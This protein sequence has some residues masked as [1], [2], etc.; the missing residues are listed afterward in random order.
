MDS[1]P[2]KRGR[3]RRFDL[4]AAAIQ[5][6]RKE[7]LKIWE[8]AQRC[9]CSN[10]TVCGRLK[11]AEEKTPAVT[12]PVAPVTETASA[13]LGPEPTAPETQAASTMPNAVVEP[14]PPPSGSTEPGSPDIESGRPEVEGK[15]GETPPP[16]AGENT[17][18]VDP[19]STPEDVPQSQSIILPGLEPEAP[20]SLTGQEK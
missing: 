12:P 14:L 8:I 6:L 18:T 5:S 2:R 15:Y 10:A 16:S 13:P 3:P 4:D 9:N 11:E 1:S 7:G 19:P 20:P 17:P